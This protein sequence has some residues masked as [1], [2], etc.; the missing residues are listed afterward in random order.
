[1]RDILDGAAVELRS[2][3][4]GKPVCLNWLQLK[5]QEFELGSES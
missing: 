2:G 4:G 5:R 1:M 3:A